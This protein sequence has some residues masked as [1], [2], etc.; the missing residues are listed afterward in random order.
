M[1]ICFLNIR[2]IS[3][4]EFVPEGTTVN[5]TFHVEVLKRLSDSVRRKRGEPWRDGSLS[6][7][8]DNASAHSLLVS[9]CLAGKGI[10]AMEHPPCSPDL[11][12]TDFWL[13]AKLKRVLKGK[14]FSDVE[15][16]KSEE[17]KLADI[18]VAGF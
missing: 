18:P 8:H 6:P 11:A 7:R 15:D 12:P 4:F 9:Q 17:K 16:I 5:Q 1:L 2:A 10:S 14:R 13:F 3:H